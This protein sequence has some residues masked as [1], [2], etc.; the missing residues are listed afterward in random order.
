VLIGYAFLGIWFFIGGVISIGGSR[1]EAAIDGLGF[2][3]GFAYVILSALAGGVASLS[4]WI[5]GTK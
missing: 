3:I 2:V 4:G 5:G 1:I